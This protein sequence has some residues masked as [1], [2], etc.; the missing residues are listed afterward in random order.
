M[1]IKSYKFYKGIFDLASS[2]YI[3]NPAAVGAFFKGALE[4]DFDVAA[5]LWEY[6]ITD[7]IASKVA[8]AKASAALGENALDLFLK[9]N[10]LRTYRLTVENEAMT[11]VL[12][13]M[14]EKLGGGASG[15]LIY[16]L[17]GNKLPDADIIIKAMQKSPSYGAS[18]KGVVETLFAEIKKKTGS[19][20]VT[21]P[22]KTAEFL[23]SNIAKIK[24]SEKALL[25]QRIKEIL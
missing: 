13:S 1:N 22:K 3:N 14:P 18:M 9:K 24:T 17:M 15:V 10:V 11:N 20:K 2:D 4:F 5:E 25:E 19:V 16:F 12:Y 23:L 8:P 6:L 7:A 21:M